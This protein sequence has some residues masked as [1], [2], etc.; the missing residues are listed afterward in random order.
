MLFSERGD[1]RP[2]ARL[3]GVGCVRRPGV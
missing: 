2:A 1:V 3:P